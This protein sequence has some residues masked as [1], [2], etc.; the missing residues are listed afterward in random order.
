MSYIEKLESYKFENMLMK[1]TYGEDIVRSELSMGAYELIH[2][3]ER[4]IFF[5]KNFLKDYCRL[6]NIPMYEK[7]IDFFCVYGGRIFCYQDS[8]VYIKNLNIYYLFHHC[9]LNLNNV[10]R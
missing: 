6:R 8:S 4:G 5:N 7:V 9:F 3:W 1:T 2:E 10:E